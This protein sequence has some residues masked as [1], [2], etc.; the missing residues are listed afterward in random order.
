MIKIVA[1]MPVNPEKIEEFKQTAKDLV[2]ESAAESGN[3]SYSL[4]VSKDDPTL[5]AIMETWKDQEAIDFHNATKH[6]TELLPK[7]AEMCVGD[8]AIDLFDEIVF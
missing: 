3:V 7:L 5:F 6:F 4:N 8:I 2:T 1:K